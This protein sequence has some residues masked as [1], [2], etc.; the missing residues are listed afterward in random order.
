MTTREPRTIQVPAGTISGDYPAPT[1]M[2]AAVQSASKNQP[3]S[4]SE[5]PAPT[6]H[7]NF[8]DLL[9]EHMHTEEG[10]LL[11]TKMCNQLT[12]QM[13]F[14][15]DLH[16]KNNM[17]EIPGT[18]LGSTTRTPVKGS[19]PTLDQRNERDEKHRGEEQHDHATED[20][21]FTPALKPLEIALACE[22]ARTYLYEGVES[23][24]AHL[25]RRQDI[26]YRGI[27]DLALKFV[28]AESAL[29]NRIENNKL[30]SAAK[31]TQIKENAKQ[32]NASE[33][34]ALANE[35]RKRQRFAGE[36]LNRMADVLSE[37]DGMTI[38]PSANGWNKLPREMQESMILRVR[39][40][41]ASSVAPQTGK[42]RITL[43]GLPEGD[44]RDKL[45]TDLMISELALILLDAWVK[46]H[47]ASFKE[48]KTQM[49]QLQ[50]R[51][52]AAQ[53]R[54]DRETGV[55]LGGIKDMAEDKL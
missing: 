2:A 21:G 11:A 49:G 6:I 32:F 17:Q 4:F 10:Q 18:D 33:E 52:K 47:C 35:L 43:S 31:Q 7:A 50:K 53:A 36:A 9:D 25:P 3:E 8:F 15:L 22:E 16:V 12:G 30:P 27:P 54:R 14:Q 38:A 24:N 39:N 28:S 44:L 37:I 1:T 48:V 45:M 51:L 42:I 55:D 20:M 13:V 41:I 29:R 26:L 46:E 23:Q 34:E 5:E 19:V 40:N